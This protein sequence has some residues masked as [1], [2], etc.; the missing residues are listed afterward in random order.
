MA[1][2]SVY[3]ALGGGWQLRTGQNLLPADTRQQMEKRTDWG[4]IPDEG[5][6]LPAVEDAPKGRTGEAQEP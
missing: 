1:L 6:R 3:Q 2:V 4:R 5:A